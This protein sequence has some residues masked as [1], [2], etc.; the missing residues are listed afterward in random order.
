VLRVVSLHRYPV[1]SCR[2]ESVAELPV[3]R[4][5][6]AGDRRFMLVDDA[7]VFLTQREHH[8]LAL[9]VPRVSPRTLSLTAPGM[10]ELEVALDA[11]GRAKRDVTVWRFET[12]G[13]DCGDAAA[14]WFSAYLGLPVHLAEFDHEAFR[15]ANPKYAPEGSSAGLFNDGYPVLLATESSLAD[16]N[17]RLATPVPM[18]RFRPNVV[19][20]GSAPF[21][22]DRWTRLRIGEVDFHVAKPCQRCAITT[23]DQHT[24][25]AGKEPLATLATF[26]KR[27][28]AVHFAVNLVH[29]GTGTLRVGDVVH[30]ESS[31]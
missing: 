3:D 13:I 25:I 29:L 26:R 21:E 31:A 15:P 18:E 20:T 6:P 5:G 19:V 28:G 17:A 22:E 11:G 1:K 27:D 7:G 8:R 16:L 10:P 9:V 2:G 30:V 4:V 14:E 23:V 24:G 12:A